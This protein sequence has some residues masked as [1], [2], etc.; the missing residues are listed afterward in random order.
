MPTHLK[1]IL[2]KLNF[3][4]SQITRTRKI[5]SNFIVQPNAAGAQIHSVSVLDRRVHIYITVCRCTACTPTKLNCKLLIFLLAAI[6]WYWKLNHDTNYEKLLINIVQ[7]TLLCLCKIFT[8][9]MCFASFVSALALSLSPSHSL[10]THSSSHE[11][12]SSRAL[13]TK[14]LS[15]I[16]SP[17]YAV[18]CV[19]MQMLGDFE[20]RT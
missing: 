16:R 7:Y 20:R 5:R 9:K 18:R 2:K 12:V 3:R 10:D 13:C 1:W 19:A 11:R 15:S 4:C 17:V 6:I 8:R 14:T